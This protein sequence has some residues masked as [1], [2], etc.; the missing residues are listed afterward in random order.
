MTKIKP[1]KNPKATEVDYRNY[2]IGYIGRVIDFASKGNNRGIENA[3]R[4][5]IKKAER[6]GKGVSAHV[7]RE[8]KKNLKEGLRNEVSNSVIK[9]LTDRA[10]SV[11]DKLRLNAFVGYNTVLIRNVSGEVQLKIFDEIRKD[12]TGLPSLE[13]RIKDVTGFSNARVKLIARDQTS[14]LN[15]ELSAMR[16]KAAGFTKYQ[17]ATSGDERVRE[18][19]VDL[20]GNVYKYDE[21][22][23]ERDGLQ[24]GQP[25]NCR[26]LA[27]PI[28]DG[29]NDE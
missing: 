22:T 15:S 28:F 25:I 2:L 11:D 6:V 18:E 26:C 16:H 5:A 17:W 21:P 9:T 8:I 10:L 4:A 19:H 14:K 27:E 7:I 23:D 13:Q 20:G 29:L 24:P 3:T 1:P 12:P